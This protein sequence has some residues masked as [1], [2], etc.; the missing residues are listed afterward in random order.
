LSMSAARSAAAEY[1][2]S[3]WSPIPVKKGSKA[4]S[5][6][7]L[8]P[9]L[10][11]KATAEEL[12]TWSWAG[13]G[14][15]TG[16]VSDVLV[17]DVD[18]PEGEAELKKHGHPLTPMVR[19]ASGGLHLYFKHP[20]G[21]VRTG[22]RV[23]PGLDVKARG[24]YVVAPP[25]VG[26]NG[27]PYEWIVSPK[28][29]ELAE[30]PEWLR[31]LVEAPLGKG[32]A[33]PIG[34]KIPSGK[35]N[36]ALTSMAGTMRRRGMDEEEIFAALSVANERRCEPA[37]EAEEIRKIAA[38]VGRYAPVRD[39]VEVSFNS[40][41][42]PRQSSR[43]NLTD[44]GNAER[45]VYRHGENVRFCYPWRKW[46]VWSGSRWERDEA[47]RVFKLAK[48][49]V[50]GI[51]GEAANA[52]DADRRKALAKHASG[53]ES[54]AKI[55]AML[56]LSKPEVPVSPD[57]LDAAPWLLNAPNG[58]VDLRTGELRE[59][60]REDLLT[61]MA[62]AEHRP[63]TAA[64]VWEAFLERALPG[65]ELRGFVQRAAGY[66]ATG[67]TS[68]QCMLINHGP[69]A[70]GK[71]TF[72]EALAAALGDYAMRTPTEMLM[73]KRGGGVPNDVARLRGARFVTASETEEGRRLAESLIKDLTGQDTISA[74][75]MR[76]EFFDFK[77]THK[78]WLSTNHKP[79]IRGTDNAIW[80]R[81]RLVPW[82]VSIPPAEQ[83]KKLP[84]K[85]RAE[86]P[87]ILA[88]CVEGCL[89]WRRG[90]LQAPDE[91][92]RA[93]G[94]YRSEM[95]IIGAFLRDECELG[96]D[97]KATLKAVYERYEEW[98]EEGGER[99][100]SKRK[101]NARLSERGQFADRRSGPGGLREWHGL[102]LLTKEDANFAG[103]L[104]ERSEK[105]YKQDASA[106]RD[107][108]VENSVSSS[109]ASVK[110]EQEARIA[111]LM[112]KGFAE[113]AARAEVLAVDH[114]V[115]CGCAV[116]L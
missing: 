110:V 36:A 23:A 90:G 82:A 88:W 98:C 102:R 33:G 56:E 111:A 24:G 45:F 76:G 72:H 3:G 14:I 58:T 6:S 85:L 78:L 37:L 84:E 18:G 7:R 34:E 74:R 51:Y 27:K 19:T 91:V 43:F 106:S 47:G 86:L 83:D 104:T 1:R 67:D 22:I 66:S 101:F 13:V 79:E 40:H 28:E 61:K 112:R 73:S 60:R 35:R 105:S 68:E 57:E 21:D 92:R 59:H 5:L 100:E 52:E 89:D 65:E 54:E 95:D 20:P 116:C 107:G 46:L 97:F 55:R 69:G 44:L 53:S 109:V 38:S 9:Y 108:N 96:H 16:P 94:A 4:T 42:G 75:F 15:V 77:P 113:S 63:G 32:P 48:D 99:A 41:G 70:N 64:S 115:G 10:E 93:T 71:S 30:V 12:G 103:K 87:G 81:I 49:T 2:E 11:R 50:R 39:V 29:A 80:R 17:L 8:A 62:G 31:K 114:P 26:A 25:S